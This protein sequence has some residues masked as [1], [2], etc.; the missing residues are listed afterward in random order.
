MK[1]V[2]PQITW[3]E[4]PKH[5]DVVLHPVEQNYKK[6]LLTEWAILWLIGFAV[7]LTAIF[8]FDAFHSIPVFLLII[9]CIVLLAGFHF[10]SITKSF[11]HM[12]YAMR[13]HDVLF[14]KGWL[15]QQMHIVPLSKIQHCVIKKGPLERKYKLASLQLF[16]AANSSFADIKIGGLTE[17]QAERLKEWVLSKQMRYENS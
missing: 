14:R 7:A 1:L 5:E 17:E 12:A 9:A 10:F 16:T 4:I 11:P 13:E 8:F 15:F 3:E 6:V 2:H